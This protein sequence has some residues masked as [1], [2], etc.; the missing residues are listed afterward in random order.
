MGQG[1]SYGLDWFE[2][3]LARPDLVLQDFAAA[4]RPDSYP[5]SQQASEWF[6]VWLARCILCRQ[7]G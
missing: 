7:A 2:G 6:A 4:V 5:V 3:A 1:P